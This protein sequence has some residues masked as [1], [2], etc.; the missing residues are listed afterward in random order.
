MSYQR[1]VGLGLCVVDHIYVVTPASWAE[2]R[3]RYTE[4]RVAPG[5][6]TTTALAQAARLGCN[7]HVLSVVGDDEGGQLI[8]RSLRAAGVKTRRLI[9]S[10]DHPTTVAVVLVER[11]G[12]DR[13]FL[14]PDRRSLERSAPELDLA[15]IDAKTLL[16]VDGHFP[17]QALRAV[18]RARG[19][20]AT[21]MG[22]FNRPEPAI[23]AL[24]PFVDYPVVP[25]EFAV[26]YGNGD[27]RRAIRK[28]RE[29]YGGNPIVTQGTRGGLYWADGRIRRYRASRVRVRDTTGAGDVFH[30]ALAAGLVQGLELID[31]LDLAARAAAL[32]CTALGGMGR[33]MTRDEAKLGRRSRPTQ[34]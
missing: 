7:A 18:K 10:A 17:R 20:G 26:A 32:N 3:L 34:P 11:S 14:V 2:T 27:A 8:G 22:D 12:G 1:V 13:R 9:V 21:V 28:L 15:A 29:H 31:A 30:G 16:L 25:E 23:R 33:L 19:L 6:M 24:L 5:G 4:R